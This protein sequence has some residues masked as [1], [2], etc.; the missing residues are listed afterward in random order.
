MASNK[1]TQQ[2]PI[3]N[4]STRMVLAERVYIKSY[5]DSTSVYAV[6]AGQAKLSGGD[7][8]G[9]TDLGIVAG[10][11]VTLTYNKETRYIET[12]IERIRRGAYIT[13][14]TAQATFTLEQFDVTVIEAISAQTGSAVTGG[15]KLIF[16]PDDLIEKALVFVGTN[17]VDG[18]EVHTYCP[19]VALSFQVQDQDDSRV[20]GVTADMFANPSGEFFHMYIFT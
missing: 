7:P 15:K 14:K 17:K 2:P 16:G 5:P 13:Q 12:G 19:W 4:N 18:K 6:G 8:S 11:K 10:S 1:Y 3:A 20:M 9:F